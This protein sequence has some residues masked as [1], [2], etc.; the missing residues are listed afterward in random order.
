MTAVVD[1]RLDGQAAIVTGASAGLG[2]IIARG[3]ADAGCAVLLAARRGDRLD[4][5]AREVAAAGGRAVAHP[6]DLRDPDHPTRLV[7]A[8]MHAFGRLDGVVLNAA[9]NTIAA[10][11]DEDPE[12]FMDVLRVNVGAQAALAAAAA[13][14]MIAGGGGGWMVLMGSILGRKAGTGPGV[15]AYVASKS[16][17]EGLT[18][19]LARQWA[20]HRIRVNALAPG[21]FPTEMNAP[22]TRAPGRREAI[23]ARTPIG[24]AGEPADLV[25]PA[26]FLASDASRFVTGHVLPV[27]G[28]MACW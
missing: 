24:R 3:L 19:E 21:Y 25:G 1:L 20:P 14:A 27:D 13:R 18:R 11:E 8:C 28:G 2:A 22:M 12:A 5:L 7:D 10:A 4:A 15:A 23:V 16:A 6:A 26:L 9:T 17:V